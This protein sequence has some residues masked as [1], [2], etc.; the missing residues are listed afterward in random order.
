LHVLLRTQIANPTVTSDAIRF[1]PEWR[2]ALRWN[3]AAELA[4]GQPTEVIQ[5]CDKRAKETLMDLEGFDREDAAL[6][7]E[8]DMSQAYPSGQFS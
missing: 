2:I 6:R 7:I 5:Y 8:P 4:Q 1:P 3:L